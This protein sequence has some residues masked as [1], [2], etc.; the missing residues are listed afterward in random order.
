MSIKMRVF[1]SL[2]TEFPMRTKTIDSVNQWTTITQRNEVRNEER[3]SFPWKWT[4]KSIS[5]NVA[6]LSVS[7]KVQ[8]VDSIYKWNIFILKETGIRSVSFLIF[9]CVFFFVTLLN[10]PFGA[11]VFSWPAL[12][13]MLQYSTSKHICTIFSTS[14]WINHL[15]KYVDS[16]S[17]FSF[18]LLRIRFYLMYEV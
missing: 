15:S 5:N 6:W 13:L 18:P 16:R 17:E 3:V 14:T 8:K 11:E 9:L 10:M 2:H 7:M 4:W 1:F 12:R